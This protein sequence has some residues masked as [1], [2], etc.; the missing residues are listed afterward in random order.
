MNPKMLKIIPAR[1]RKRMVVVTATIFMRAM[2][3]F[4]GLA[5][6]I[7][8]LA[9]IIDAGNIA[10]NPWLDRIYTA[11]GFTDTRMFAAA[12]CAAVVAI[13]IVKN[14]LALLLF[15][16][17]RNF[18]FDLYGYF[19][20]RLYITYHDRGLSFI[21]HHN[22]ALL[23]RNV[24]IPMRFIMGVLMP[25]AAI[26][27]DASLFV[28]LFA[29]MMWFSPVTA[30][31]AVFVFLP[32][33]ALYYLLVR[34]RLETC[35]RQEEEVTRSRSRCVNETFRGYADMEINNAFPHMLDRFD[36]YQRLIIEMRRRRETI[37]KLPGLFIETALAVGMSAIVIVC[38]GGESSQAGMMFGIFAVAALRLLP[39]IRSI[40]GNWTVI[41][42]NRYTVD[43]LAEA[44]EHAPEPERDDRRMTF[45]DRITVEN[46]SFRFDDGR[47][48]RAIFTNLNL[49]I[50][51]GELLGIRGI[52]GAGKTTL[53]NLLL[54][55]YKPTAGRIAVDGTT[56]DD[57]TRRRWQNNIGYVSQNVFI[58]DTTFI[59][60]VALGV[61]RDEIDRDRAARSLEAARLGDFIA[62]LPAGMDA[63]IGE[64]G[65]R[66]SGGQRQRIGIARA[67]YKQA[68]VLFFD[69][70]TSSLDNR[71]EQSINQSVRELSAGN[72]ELTIVVIAHRESSLDCCDRIITIGEDDTR[73]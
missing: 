39:S 62:S 10:A 17:E 51:K 11:I 15:R 53:F 19:S 2:L 49:T 30:V 7:P 4:I 48:D 1:Y 12:V 33:V 34:R 46:L 21:K 47:D 72:R 55:F 16:V 63:A 52:S 23:V 8:V 57:T 50:R 13:I 44:D 29:A 22:S 67:L 64:C 45:S 56:L 59:E 5:V 18:V 42:Y 6:L 58:S 38:A 32:S 25:A 73:I 3:N 26:I 66:L 24:G 27:C 36:D 70:A 69:E 35:G 65:C 61:P 9:L 54:G 71:T 20:R 68:D 31:T 40:V 41:K 28:I 43:I 37:N 60:N 14:L